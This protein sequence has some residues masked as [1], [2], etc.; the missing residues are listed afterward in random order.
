[1]ARVNV[2]VPD[3]TLKAIDK[4]AKAANCGRSAW[5]QRAAENH[6]LQITEVERAADNLAKLLRTMKSVTTKRPAGKRGAEVVAFA[7]RAAERCLNPKNR[8]ARKPK[9]R[10]GK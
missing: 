9:R 5:L 4:A 1:M 8:N 3:Q 2:Y 10:E 6:L 7:P